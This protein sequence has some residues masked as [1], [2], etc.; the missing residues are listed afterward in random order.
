M[1]GEMLNDVLKPMSIFR[2]KHFDVVNDASAMKV[3]TDGVLLGAW[4]TVMPSD[5][6][7]LDIGTGTGV[8]AMIVAQR[9]AFSMYGRYSVIEDANVRIVG[10]DIDAV[11]AEEASRNF[12]SCM[13]RDSMEA[14]WTPLSAFEADRTDSFDLIVSNPPY[15]END[16][17]CPSGRRSDARHTDALSYADVLSFAAE[18]LSP[19]GR[20]SVVLPVSFEKRLLACASDHSLFLNRVMY[21]RSTSR[22]PFLRIFAEFSRVRTALQREELTIHDGAGYDSEYIKKTSELYLRF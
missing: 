15:F 3:N 11:S 7:I 17:K 5:N 13:W 21:V 6:T 20:V 9:L 22:K 8:I 18:R 10:I 4:C 12:S 19:S 1:S 2:F 14:V 16:L